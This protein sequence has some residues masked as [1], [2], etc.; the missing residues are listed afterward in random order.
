[1]FFSWKS[2]S[3]VVRKPRS[4]GRLL[5]R[6]QVVVPT[7]ALPGSQPRLLGMCECL[8]LEVIPVP[9]LNSPILKPRGAEVSRPQWAPTQTADLRATYMLSLFQVTKFLSSLSVTWPWITGT[10]DKVICGLVLG[11]LSGSEERKCLVRQPPI[12]CQNCFSTPTPTPLA[13]LSP[14][15]GVFCES[16]W[17]VARK[18][19]LQTLALL[20]PAQWVPLA[21]LSY[22]RSKDSGSL[23]VLLL[24]F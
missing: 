22:S 12:Y 1:M 5:V 20:P 17:L 18:P 13:L 16:H 6:I 24:L 21:H 9:I 8:I 11:L 3:H 4:R 14:S 10:Q 2:S 15:W 7:E 19:Y 23:G